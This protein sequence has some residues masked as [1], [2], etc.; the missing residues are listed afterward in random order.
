MNCIL[1]AIMSLSSTR[2]PCAVTG[3][4]VAPQYDKLVSVR[5]ESCRDTLHLRLY[6]R[7]SRKGRYCYIHT[8]PTIWPMCYVWQRMRSGILCSRETRL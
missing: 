3:V 1:S 6:F 8:V 7:R 5:P 2:P 4:N